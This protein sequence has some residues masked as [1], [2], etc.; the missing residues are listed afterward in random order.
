MHCSVVG[1]LGLI[2]AVTGRAPHGGA[3]QDEGL[4]LMAASLFATTAVEQL[5]WRRMPRWGLC[6]KAAPEG[7]AMPAG[8]RR[9]LL[10]STRAG[11]QPPALCCSHLFVF[12]RPAWVPTPSLQHGSHSQTCLCQ[13]HCPFAQPP[14]GR[15]TPS[16][17]PLLLAEAW[18]PC[19]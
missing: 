17:A 8:W 14:V 16:S 10:S 18:P 19:C 11:Q 7:L 4:L 1:E 2:V 6:L 13:G 3:C 9:P 12:C 5:I 15:W